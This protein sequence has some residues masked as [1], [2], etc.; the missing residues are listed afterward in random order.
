MCTR[1]DQG[2]TCTRS[3]QA[4]SRTV[5]TV[6]LHRQSL[7]TS[8]FGHLR[9]QFNATVA[10]CPGIPDCYMVTGIVLVLT[11]NGWMHA[12]GWDS[13]PMDDIADQC[14]ITVRCL[15]RFPELGRR[16]LVRELLGAQ[17]CRSCH[18]TSL[19]W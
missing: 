13:A 8:R 3:T 4:T 10:V 6:T 17:Q 9:R 14:V 11:A 15:P 1:S 18:S 16:C 19:N 5:M 7:A 12:I 2:N